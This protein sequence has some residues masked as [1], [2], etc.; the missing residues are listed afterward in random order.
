MLVPLAAEYGFD[1]LT[2][3]LALA[4]GALFFLFV[5]LRDPSS[6]LRDWTWTLAAVTYLG[7]LGAH[8]VLLRNADGDGHLVLLAVLATWL[9][10]TASYFAGRA[11]G[12]LRVI[13]EISPGKTLEG[14][15]AGLAAAAPSVLLLDSAL[16]TQ[17]DA[18][19]AAALGLLLAPLAMIGDLA[20]SLIKRGAGIKDASELIPG[21][22]GVLDRLDSLLFTVPGVYYF[23]LWVS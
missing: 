10:D 21:H 11:F 18:V 1:E 9:I 3:A 14:Y 19:E 15:L 4:T 13:P 17:F 23:V 22:G 8:L 2:G 16:D 12:R 6:G 7:F 5:S 20:E